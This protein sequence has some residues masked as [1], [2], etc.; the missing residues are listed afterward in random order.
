MTGIVSASSSPNT[1]RTGTMPFMALHLLSTENTVHLLRHDAESFIWLFLWVCGCSDG[2]GKEVP[3]A[4]YKRWR[5]LEMSTCKTERGAFLSAVELE[6]INVSTHHGPNGYF[7]LFLAMLLQQLR[8]HIWMNISTK[9]DRDAKDKK[10]IALL[11]TVLIPKFKEV[12]STL[13]QKFSPGDWSSEERRI[14]IL[15][16][17]YTTVAS[18]IHSAFA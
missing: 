7:C 9:A 10:D 1:D 16:Y 3:V 6:Y 5:H 11:E 2:S 13:N 14:E 8:T 12:R 18:I 17:I 15:K 4:P